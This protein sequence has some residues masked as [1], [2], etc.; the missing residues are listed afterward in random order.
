MTSANDIGFQLN[1]ACAQGDLGVVQT[2]AP[3]WNGLTYGKFLSTAVQFNQMAVT[4]YLL[5]KN[6]LPSEVAR[7][8]EYAIDGGFLDLLPV[9]AEYLDDYF[10]G[11]ALEQAARMGK[12]TA[13]QLLVPFAPPHF[14]LTGLGHALIQKNDD[15][16]DILA[17]LHSWG[18]IHKN[19]MYHS[20]SNSNQDCIDYYR[21]WFAN[22]QTKTVLT[23][24]VQ[25]YT[26]SDVVR[27]KI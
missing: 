12:A 16:I 19:L 27:R 5:D 25:P 1:R 21:Q 11:S 22:Q 20:K 6:N 24:V 8:M 23:E 14:T 13:V 9:L 26:N 2:L 17:P 7:A 4:E 3:Q 18:D 10:C 15:I